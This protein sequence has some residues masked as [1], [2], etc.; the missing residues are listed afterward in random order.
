MSPRPAAGNLLWAGAAA[1]GWW[2]F[3][4]ALRDPL[5][6]QHRLLARYLQEN[7]ETTAGRAHDFAGIVRR[8][9]SRGIVRPLAL[10]D[11][12]RRR[13]P[14]TRYDD[15]APFVDRIAR[16]ER[17]LLTSEPVRRLVPSSGSSAAVKLVPYTADLQRELGRAIDAWIADLFLARPELLAGPA[18][19]SVSPAVRV[20]R[21]GS[22][23]PVGF[24]DDGAYLGGVRGALAKSILAVPA[25]VRLVGDAESFQYVTLAF[26][27][28]A[29]DLR[30]VSVW[31]PSFLDRL[32]DALPAWIERIALDLE[33]GTLS[34]P[35]LDEAAA[36]L[37]RRFPADRA[38]ARHLRQL[39]RLTPSALWPRLAVVSCWSDGAAS[40]HAAALARRLGGIAIQ[41]KGL[42]A[43]EGVVTIPFRE[44]H[45]LAIRS[46][47]FEFVADDGR[48][49]LAHELATGEEYSVVLT[50][51]GGLYRYRLGDR[52]RVDGW[53]D[54]TP[55]LRFV[56]RDDAVSDRF[57]EKLSDGF[58]A[59]VLARLFGREWPP[60]AMLAPAATSS[61]LAYTLFV[62][63]GVRVDP[64]ALEQELRRNP[65]YAWC[66]ELGQLRPARVVRVAPG[67]DRRYVDACVSR[68]QR[69]GD[70]KPVSLHRETG[71]ETVFAAGGDSGSGGDRSR[72]AADVE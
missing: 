35:R 66:V 25:G 67:A 21:R 5:R 71:W 14:F 26:L 50:T 22:S 32:L 28:R 33:Q 7:R 47:V 44:R 6:Q 27:L 16:G 51:G 53:V 2:R 45:P 36:G 40:G 23:V 11:E 34:P 8:A 62:E 9:H 54:A 57:G 31:H 4:S 65:H 68:G 38:R 10:F 39:S 24:E 60:F 30:L 72:L 42:L 56:G 64:R 61:G 1:R 15:L 59:G 43:T 17:G 20:E 3:R 29:R 49:S 19:W 48:S 55:S 63:G 70:V 37:A 46:H 69:L 52:V 12:Y 58:V 41:A 18:Y 13:V